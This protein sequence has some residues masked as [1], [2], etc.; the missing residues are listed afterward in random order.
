MRYWARKDEAGNTTTVESYSH[1]FDVKGAVEITQREYDEF[2]AFL[3]K[4][5]PKPVRNLAKEIDDLKARI[6]KLEKK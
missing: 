5:E 2:I 3:P 1:N 6:E 4:L